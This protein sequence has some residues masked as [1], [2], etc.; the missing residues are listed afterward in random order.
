MKIFVTNR[1]PW[2]AG[3]L[4]ALASVRQQGLATE[5]NLDLPP[6]AA[7]KINYDRDIRPILEQSCLRCHGGQKPRSHFRLDYSETALAGGDEN[8]NDIVPGNSRAS[9]LI[10]YVAR[11]VPDMEM[12]PIGRGDPL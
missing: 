2:S 5:T 11:Q 3:I 1:V 4:L 9:L 12:P 6:A 8:T 7:I 10:A